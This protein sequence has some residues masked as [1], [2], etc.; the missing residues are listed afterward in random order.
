MKNSDLQQNRRD[1]LL[2]LSKPAA[3]TSAVA[4]M[5]GMVTL[6]H[7]AGAGKTAAEIPKFEGKLG[8]QK[9][10]TILILGGTGF[11]GPHQV[12]YALSRGHKVTI[13]N[14]GRRPKE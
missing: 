2:Q 8:A 6:S 5:P 1:W 3:S 12:R 11:T 14:R 7:A 10:L 4:A 13:F 9:P